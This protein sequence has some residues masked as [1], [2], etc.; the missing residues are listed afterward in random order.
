MPIVS[1]VRPS[2]LRKAPVEPIA[3]A[4][5]PLPFQSTFRRKIDG[6]VGSTKPP[7]VQV[8]PSG[9]ER[10]VDSS[11][12]A[13]KRVPVQVTPSRSFSVPELCRVQVVASG[14]V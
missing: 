8:V 11:P 10:I 3:S 14:L 9:L 4:T 7:G 13:T 12:A 1:Q 6:G 5:A 2:A